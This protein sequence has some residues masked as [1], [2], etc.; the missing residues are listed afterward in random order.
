MT[1]FAPLVTVDHA[2][3][4]SD[5]GLYA[6]FGQVLQAFTADADLHVVAIA[7]FADPGG[8]YGEGDA[9]LGIAAARD[10]I[11]GP[12][13]LDSGD[14]VVTYTPTPGTWNIVELP[15]PVDL[16][17]GTSYSIIAQD[18]T[19]ATSNPVETIGPVT[20]GGMYNGP[21]P[22]TFAAG[23]SR[24]RF[25]LLTPSLMTVAAGVSGSSLTFSTTV[26]PVFHLR[27]EPAAGRSGGA[28]LSIVDGA[29]AVGFEPAAGR[30]GSTLAPRDLPL[31][32]LLT[33]AAGQSG[34]SLTFA[35]KLT[36]ALEPAAGVGGSVW[37]DRPD[38]SD[39]P[40]IEL[41]LTLSGQYL[42]YQPP[43]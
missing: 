21:A 34:S 19:S 35:G 7:T 12:D 36:L 25:Q 30:S 20:V 16:V 10:G 11:T 26:F 37:G 6:F 18:F 28:L 33:E 22:W 4:A 41:V 40:P 1:G 39:N 32:L 2:P 23:S 43:A 9:I 42:C 8:D 13:Y 3:H 5:L 27:P 14:A 17:S 31:S 38:L 29:L 24:L 15:H